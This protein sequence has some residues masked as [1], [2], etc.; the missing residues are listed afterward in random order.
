V[1]DPAVPALQDPGSQ[2]GGHPAAAI[3]GNVS[4]G[5]TAGDVASFAPFLAA[6]VY[7]SLRTGEH[8]YYSANQASA[9]LE[10]FL[11]TRKISGLA[12]STVS[13]NATIPYATGSATLI[14]RGT[15]QLVQVYVSA[16]RTGDQ[17]TITQLNIY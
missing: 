14:F 12:F 15:R 11:R 9:L 7:V 6:Q 5:L 1:Q 17:W 3:F 13:V 10:Y 4:R 8:G 16:E 2:K